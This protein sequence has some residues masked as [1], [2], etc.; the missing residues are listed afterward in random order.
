MNS[1]SELRFYVADTHTDETR[2]VL[3]VALNDNKSGKIDYHGMDVSWE[4]FPESDK[5]RIR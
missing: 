2:S 4:L 3:E 5:Y 1:G